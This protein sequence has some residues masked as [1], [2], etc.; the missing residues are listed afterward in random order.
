[1]RRAQ[2][3]LPDAGGAIDD[4]SA[5]IARAVWRGRYCSTALPAIFQLKLIGIH[6][7]IPWHDEMIAMAW[8]HPNVFIGSDAHRPKYWPESF[9]RFI[10]SGARTR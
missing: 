3:S 8:K 10:N 7:G 9:V 4:L 5:D 1:M 2:Y 6:I